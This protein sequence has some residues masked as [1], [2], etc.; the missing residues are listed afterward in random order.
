M[1]VWFI[2]A[3]SGPR[4]SDLLIHGLTAKSHHTPSKLFLYMEF[5]GYLKQ[6]S[7]REVWKLLPLSYTR[8]VPSAHPETVLINETGNGYK[9]LDR[10]DI[11]CDSRSLV[12]RGEQEYEERLRQADG[13]LCAMHDSG[14][15]QQGSLP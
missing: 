14:Q 11:A 1:A 6:A 9:H 15:P 4:V 12:V 8:L 10:T 13:I 5:I 2:T 3:V 7:R